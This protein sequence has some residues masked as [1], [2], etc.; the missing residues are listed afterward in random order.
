M[1]GCLS[2]AVAARSN[3][4]LVQLGSSRQVS[5]ASHSFRIMPKELS[6]FIQRMCVADG[7]SA[8]EAELVA[9]HLV[10][11]NLTGH[12]SHGVGMMRQ[13]FVTGSKH[14]KAATELMK[15]QQLASLRQSVSS[16]SVASAA[17]TP[18]TLAPEGAAAPG[19][20][21]P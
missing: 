17:A 4:R 6:E 18:P 14:Q 19:A 11:A 7:S 12:D 15:A 13:Y 2:T 1:L 5:S 20:P 10:L 16:G 3:A 8:V 9:D 21:S